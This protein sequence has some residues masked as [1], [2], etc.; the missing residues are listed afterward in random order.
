MHRVARSYKLVH[1][2]HK[3]RWREP[4]GWLGQELIVLRY[5]DVSR[6][7]TSRPILMI[8]PESFILLTATLSEAA[9][10]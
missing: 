6:T 10:S 3:L 4:P 1:P 8:D 9:P 7:C 2:W 5:R